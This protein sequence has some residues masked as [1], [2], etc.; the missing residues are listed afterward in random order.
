[1]TVSL[2]LLPKDTAPLS[3]ADEIVLKE[4]YLQFDLTNEPVD[5]TALAIKLKR[6]VNEVPSRLS[7]ALGPYA[8]RDG[9]DRFV[10][11]LRAALRLNRLE[12]LRDAWL[13]YEACF[14]QYAVKNQLV[15]TS[16]IDFSTPASHAMKRLRHLLHHE[17][18]VSFIERDGKIEARIGSGVL[19]A[20]TLAG[21][22]ALRSGVRRTVVSNERIQSKVQLTGLALEGF[23]SFE[24]AAVAGLGPLTVL[25]G[26]NEAG[27]SN[28]VR[29]LE[30][31][32]GVASSGM[33]TWRDR[34]RSLKRATADS[35]SLAVHLSLSGA[36]GA[37]FTYR[38][39]WDGSIA[40]AIHDVRGNG[41]ANPRLVT[42]RGRADLIDD[43]GQ[44]SSLVVSKDQ[45]SLFS[46]QDLTRFRELIALRG[47]LG[48]W[49]FF[50]FEASALRGPEEGVG[51]ELSVT[52]S[53][54]PAALLSLGERDPD[55][56]KEVAAAFHALLPATERLERESS[57]SGRALLTLRERGLNDPLHHV[58]FSDG[59]L[60][61]LALLT[62]TF[63]PDPPSLVVVEEPENGLYPRLIEAMVEI[64][65]QLATRTQVVLTTH[66]VT[67]LNRLRPEE[68]V[69]IH[70]HEG[71]SQFM[72]VDSRKDIRDFLPRMGIGTQM[73]VGN[74][75]DYE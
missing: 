13:L 20:P 2:E 8:R 4:L 62:L 64:V 74:L 52:G 67:L 16:Q 47:T 15:Q 59:M 12:D 36:G 42:Q 72:R 33:S 71:A 5:G 58:D 70:R 6:Q 44:A 40:E 48:A 54:L 18:F 66:S 41:T 10:P 1:M 26:P 65:R 43:N 55:A 45:T 7:N 73:M 56:W 53:N 23:R 21:Y 9:D 3:D 35:P 60:R 11:T 24:R 30:F 39:S 57:L 38:L 17:S 63:E 34:I 19:D 14:E 69:F 31:A 29:A 75:E 51:T 28:V 61:I 22:L 68:V 27:K 50:H 32:S 49:R 25:A 37:A 46:L